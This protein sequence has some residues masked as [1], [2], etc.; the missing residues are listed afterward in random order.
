MTT[1]TRRWLSQV[2]F[3]FIPLQVGPTNKNVGGSDAIFPLAKH[4]S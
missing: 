2:G 1:A 3:S 4:R